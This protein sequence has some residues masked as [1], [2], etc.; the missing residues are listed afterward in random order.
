[1]RPLILVFFFCPFLALCQSLE[2]V[3]QKGHE[4]A[5][6]AVAI[7]PDSNYI[8]SGSKDKSAKLW[9]ISTGREVR[10]YLGHEATVTSLEFT[11]DGKTLITGSNDKSIR[12][13][14][15]ST[16]KEIYSIHTDDI[17]TDIAIDPKLHFFVV[18]GYGN[19]GYG[20]S[21]TVYDLSSKKI[22]KKITASPDKGLGSGVDVAI[23]QNGKLLAVGEDNR[24]INLYNTNDWTLEKTFQPEEGWCGGCGTRVVFGFDN[25][26]LYAASHNGPVRKYDL[27]SFKLIKT[28]EEKTDDLTGLAITGDGKTI[29]RSTEKET[30]VWDALS[31]DCITT[32]AAKDQSGFH[33]IAF[34]SNNKSLLI[35]SD[36]NTVSAWNFPQ[37]K[38]AMTFMGYLNER[39]RGGLN[40]DPNFYW[41][42]AIAKYIRLKNSLLI[43]NDGKTLIKGKFGTKVKQWDIATGKSVM[44][45]V[46]H[47][48]AVLCY[49]LS[50]DGNRLLTGGGDGKIML[51]NVDTG[52]SIQV[53]QSYRE[54]IFDIHF[55]ADETHVASS[56]WDATMKVHDLETGKMQTYFDLANASAYQ[57]IFHPNELYL[58]TARLDNTLQMWETDTKKEVRN[59]IGHTDIISSI[60]LSNDQNSLLSSSWDGTVRIW[61]VGT[62]LMT[63]KF[64]GHI[65]AVH[66]SIFSPDAKLVYSAGSDRTIR[67]WDILTSKVVRTFEGHK[68]EVTTLLFSP[69]SKM[70]MSHSV[71]GVTK[72]WDLNTGKEFFEHI[73]LGERDWMVKNPEG[74]FNTTD[75]ARRFIHFV[76]G[77]KTYSVDQFFDEFYRPDLLPKIFQNRSTESKS[78][79]GSLKNSPPPSVKLAVIP[80]VKGKAEVYVRI[81]DNGNGVENLK[82]FHN[83]KSVPLNHES[84]S[85]P[86]SRGQSTTYKHEVNLVSG[87][88]VFSATARNKDNIESDAQ[89][90][91][92]FSD[93]V[94]KNSICYVLAV[95]INEYK[96]SKLNLNFAR[97]DAE[98]FGNLVNEKSRQLF[99]NVELHTL[100]DK[101]ATRQKILNQLDELSGRISQEDVLIFYYAGHGSMI[102]NKFYFIPTESSRL[103]D[104][105][106]LHKE[107]IEASVI[108][109][110]FKNIKALK[111]LIVMDACQSG[112][113]VELLATR[114]AQE[115]KAIAQLSRSAGIHVM[116]SAG[117]EQFATEFNTLGHGLFTHVLIKGLQGEAD[118][119]PKDGKVTIYELK[120]YVDDQVPEVTRKLKG[121]PQYPYT[122]SRGHD[123]PIVMDVGAH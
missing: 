69:D 100:Y 87:S 123:F 16:G 45:F 22:L 99:K 112:G 37:N 59:F 72:F 61:D 105:S 29:A 79:Q 35:T 36:D 109:E 41:Q 23:S 30:R 108:Q 13:W 7:S 39:D 54:P 53:I 85:F 76:S 12:F 117:S 4:L 66:A 83:G 74:F 113:S 64:K 75:D 63:K 80:L 107:A 114:G 122:F 96:N 51:W 93:H 70:L 24:T 104:A 92:L 110:K 2:T 81:V 121:N 31:G 15:V 106:S 38:N 94:S 111:Q 78:I 102:D 34:T 58:F 9:E 89:T 27:D 26:T 50:R 57:L 90:A 56:S 44:E 73:H 71:D 11:A 28:Y 68:A 1:M 95:G 8:V 40:Y 20:D 6:V 52:D 55:S 103:Y 49:D 82:L 91:E 43:S 10:S 101:E 67:V 60:Q 88:N 120:S 46:G 32:I 86:K 98:S 47:K 25:K 116:A 33:E 14:D 62:G 42:S 48:K 84:L 3:V 77:L 115:E 65:G 19:S 21:I 18:A 5:V 97:A 119:A 118:G 17:I